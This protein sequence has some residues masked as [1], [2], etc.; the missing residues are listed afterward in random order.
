MSRDPGEPR[1]QGINAVAVHVLLTP[2][3]SIM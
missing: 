3:D 2:A 1:A